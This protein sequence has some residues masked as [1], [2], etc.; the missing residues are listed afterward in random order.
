MSNEGNF[1]ASFVEG[2]FG[3]KQEQA[4]AAQRKKIIQ[5]QTKLIEQQL[6]A[7]QIKVDAQTKL[8]DL[9]TGTPGEFQQI[10]SIQSPDG[11]E[12][13]QF[14]NTGRDPMGLGEM[15]VN[16][17]EGS[18]ESPE[19]SLALL[20]SGLFTAKDLIGGQ[21]QASA[22]TRDAALANILPGT[23]EYVEAFELRYGQD[24]QAILSAEL[25]GSIQEEKV[26]A[27]RGERTEKAEEKRKLKA[28]G[29]LAVKNHFVLV[30]EAIEL[31]RDLQRTVLQ[32]GM[33]LGEGLRSLTFIYGAAQEFFGKD[34]PQA[35]IIAAKQDRLSKLFSTT[36][37][38]SIKSMTGIVS[39]ARQEALL[40]ALPTLDNADVANVQLFGDQMRT[41]LDEA[42]INEFEIG[43]REFI[44]QFIAD[45]LAGLAAAKESFDGPAFIDDVT[46]KARSA[47]DAA[48]EKAQAGIDI[49]RPF[50]NSAIDTARPVVA[51]GI[52][53]AQTAAQSVIDRLL[54]ID[55]KGL[56]KEAKQRALDE[57]SRIDLKAL[58]ADAAAKAI[59]LYAAFDFKGMSKEAK[60]LAL[61]GLSRIDPNQLSADAKAKAIELYDE[62]YNAI[63]N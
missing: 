3:H 8:S 52:E 38:D 10:E 30:N 25:L 37:V 5:L 58:S 54:V 57:L 18:G 56:S 44:E 33:P 61:D 42:E 35:K 49:A 60:Q 51:S 22:F 6:T 4:D 16:F 19:A 53:Q 63:N 21:G 55:F 9:M 32:S 45:P 29:R 46:G 14:E 2:F 15:I 34:S 13:T 17:R 20:Q 47:F 7:G 43:G 31:M 11:R 24:E 28:R 36:L 23:P 12:I 40:N 48:T 41:L 62:L 39:V 27:A 59:E 26:L 1:A 50:V